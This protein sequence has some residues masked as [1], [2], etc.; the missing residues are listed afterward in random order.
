[1]YD[2]TKL[3]DDEKI[4]MMYAG[5]RD[6]LQ[7]QEALEGFSTA[8]EWIR[9][10]PKKTKRWKERFMSWLRRALGV[11][12]YDPLGKVTPPTSKRLKVRYRYESKD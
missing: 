3:S 9:A 4:V 1:M 11:Y 6:Q 10:Q 8:L 12:E 7:A 5:A 2:R